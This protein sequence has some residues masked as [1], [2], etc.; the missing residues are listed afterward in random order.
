M[1]QAKFCPENSFFWCLRIPTP[2]EMYVGNE[3]RETVLHFLVS[4]HHKHLDL[5]EKSKIDQ[6]AESQGG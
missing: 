4:Y 3:K 6:E 2:R 5:E 1:I